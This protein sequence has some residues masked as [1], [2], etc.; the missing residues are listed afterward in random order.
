[1]DRKTARGNRLG[2]LIIGLLLIILS[3]LVIARGARL[4]PQSF[5]PARAP[6]ITD[7]VRSAFLRDYPML[8]WVVAGAAIVLALLGL[9]WLLVQ[10]RS[11]RL[12]GIR[13][14]RGPAG[15]TEVNTGHVADA[16]ATEVSSQPGVLGA[17][18]ALVGTNARPAVQLR[19][20]V[21]E[22][23]PMNA[24]REQLG[25]SALP[26]MRQALETDRVPTVAQVSLES[27]HPRRNVA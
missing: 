25:G 22:T 10:G 7:S 15:V 2:L 9:R 23:V 24:I 13:L 11:Q 6:L 3:G 19:M 18:A 4:F 1:M 26:H 17:T 27:P 5:A 12:G 16:M 8:W 14:Q 21:A 20:A